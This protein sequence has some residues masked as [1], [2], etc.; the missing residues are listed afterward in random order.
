MR[1][2]YYTATS[3]DG[4]IATPDDSREW[5]FPLGDVTQT[6]Y[7]KFIQGCRLAVN[8]TMRTLLALAASLLLCW[9]ALSPART[10][11]SESTLSPPEARA[12][13][14]EAYIYGFPL[15]DNYRLLHAYFVDRYGTE[16]KAP[17]NE[18]HNESRAYTPD[19]KAIQTPNSDTPY[20]QLGTDLRAEPL[21]ITV[22]AVDKGRYYSLQFIDAYTHNYVYVGSRA[23]GN[24]AQNYLLAGPEWK[25]QQPAGVEAVIRSETNLGWIL[26]RTQ[27]FKPADLDSVKRVQSGYGVQTLSRFL[28]KPSPTAPKVEFI[29]PLPPDRQRASPEFFNVLNFVLRFC[30]THPSETALMA[31]FARL[32]IGAHGTF[33]AATLSPELRIAVEAGIADAWREFAGFKKSQIETGKRTSGDLFGTRVFL[34]NDY[35]AR[36]AGAVLGIY[37]N[38]PEEAVYQPYFVDADGSKLD[39]SPNRYT[40]HF[41][42]DQLPPVNAF[43][44]LT[45]YEM[46]SSLLVANPLERYLINSAMLPDL[47]R[48]AD[49][50]LTLYLQ[51]ESPGADKESNWLP[52]PTGAFWAVLRLYW[53]KEQV[54]NGTWQAPPLVKAIAAASTS[55]PVTVENFVRAET[56]LYLAAVVKRGAFGKFDHGRQPTRIDEQTVVR[57]NR[58]TLYS[59]A[60]FDLAAGP[61]TITLPESGDRFLSMQVISEDHYTPWVAYRAGQYVLTKEDLGTRYAIVAVRIFVAPSDTKDMEA[62]HRL[63]DVI[64]VEQKSPGTFEIPRWDPV[65]QKK[66]R[67]ALAVLGSTLPDTNWSFGMKGEVNP[68]RHLIAS[69]TA[70][71]G[72]PDKDAMYLNVTPPTND[73][74]TVY[75]LTVKD[76]PINGFW[77]ISVY[78]ANGYFEP[79]KDNAYTINSITG[80]KDVD[81][82]I[83]IRFGGCDGKAANCL[84]ITPGWNYLV[85]LYRPRQEI[86]NGTWTFPVAKPVE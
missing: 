64:T 22:P 46:P 56:D 75:G 71:G 15:V 2:Q 26:F 63:Q 38:S 36:M 57:M 30:P 32:G 85:R 45:M 61:V 25:G 50:G 69:A 65:S 35:L 27:L 79:N 81:G 54:L 4:F 29:K 40:L 34:N 67:D 19:D 21:V 39:G 31:R 6:S 41:A 74:K 53:P 17:W 80:T 78:N 12:I 7:L 28:G 58:D 49:G 82:A 23:T 52:A 48:D 18:I 10:T 14:R 77:S 13:A 73:G 66:V 51:N 1:T 60:V 11:P 16:F 68:I 33:D 62:V 37:G 72:N 5:L 76:V 8:K 44:S 3:F 70:W 83:T 55:V 20:S 43:W 59:A 84:P 24:G 47:K 86:V 42:A 9:P